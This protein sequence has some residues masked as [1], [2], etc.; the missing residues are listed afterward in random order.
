[1]TAE[2]ATPEDTS[3]ETANWAPDA[4]TVKRHALAVEAYTYGDYY[5]T[6]ECQ[7]LRDLVRFFHEAWGHLSKDLMG[8][9]I[10]QKMF[11]NIPD[12]LISKVVRKH[13]P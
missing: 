4:E 1:M 9:I 10:D 2:D 6:A 11:N 13:F 7:T 8:K 12:K 3:G 5:F